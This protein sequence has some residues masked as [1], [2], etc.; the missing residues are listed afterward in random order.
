MAD[1]SWK[2]ALVV[3]AAVATGVLIGGSGILRGGI[4]PTASAVAE[5]QSGG[6]IALVGDMSAN[7]EAPII[8]ISVPDETVM[9]YDFSYSDRVVRLSSVRSYKFDKL[10]TDWQTKGPTVED[11][12][13]FTNR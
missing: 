7:Q 12:R 3:L 6:V 2:T 5:G 13:R 8:L 11:V 4:L 10:L 1:R 9:V